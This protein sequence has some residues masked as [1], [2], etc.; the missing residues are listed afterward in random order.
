MAERTEQELLAFEAERK[1]REEEEFER[2]RRE[3]EERRN[4][5]TPPEVIEQ[6]VKAI[7]PEPPKKLPTAAVPV[8]PEK[9][10]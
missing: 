4:V 6:F 8:R 5:L 7:E 1:R 3:A 2:R 9:D 10:D